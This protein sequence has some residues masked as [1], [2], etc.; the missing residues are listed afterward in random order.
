MTEHLVMP[1]VMVA[2]LTVALYPLVPGL[3]MVGTFWPER[4]KL[5]TA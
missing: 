1:V 2:L 5:V 3:V 4:V